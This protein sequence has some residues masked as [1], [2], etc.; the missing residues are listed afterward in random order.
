MSVVIVAVALIIG[1]YFFIFSG[2]G[3]EDYTGVT[4][5]IDDHTIDTGSQKTIDVDVLNA[6]DLVAGE[7]WIQYDPTYL[8]YTDSDA[9]GNG[10]TS[11]DSSSHIVK[12][13]PIFTTG[14]KTGTVS[15]GTITFTRVT[16]GITTL[17]FSKS[18]CY[19]RDSVDTNIPIETWVTGDMI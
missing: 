7:I 16:S 10:Y 14:G 2:E 9:G 12:L 8:T 15:I 17:T 5:I 3:I 6:V 13:M 18:N 4:V 19:L 1:G 11:H